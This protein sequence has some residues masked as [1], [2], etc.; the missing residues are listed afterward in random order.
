MKT[1]P[2]GRVSVSVTMRPDLYERVL[3]VSRDQEIPLTA[4]CRQALKEYL[5]NS[6]SLGS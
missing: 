2:D 5:K 1:R 3:A 6:H 4:L